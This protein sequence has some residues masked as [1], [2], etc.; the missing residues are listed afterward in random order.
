[1][2]VSTISELKEDAGYACK[3]FRAIETGIEKDSGIPHLYINTT[4]TTSTSSEY[5]YMLPTGLT[6]VC[7]SLKHEKMSEVFI[8]LW[9]TKCIYIYIYETYVICGKTMYRSMRAVT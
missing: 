1:M 9:F 7:H 2:N 8:K 4:W 5:V 3:Y 6:Y